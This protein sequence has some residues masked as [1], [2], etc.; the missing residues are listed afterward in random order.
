MGLQAAAH[1][2]I[3][4]MVADLQDPYSRFADARETTSTAASAPL[5]TKNTPLNILN[6]FNRDAVHPYVHLQGGGVSRSAGGAGGPQVDSTGMPPP[7]SQSTPSHLAL[8]SSAGQRLVFCFS[9]FS[10]FPTPLII[11]LQQVDD[12]NCMELFFF[13]GGR[14]LKMGA[15]ARALSVSRSWAR[16]LSR[17]SY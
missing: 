9:F 8:S 2:V 16:A 11:W 5:N 14:V 15:R 13:F 1:D 6:T 3:R 4:R 12:D 7:P 10:F 17:L